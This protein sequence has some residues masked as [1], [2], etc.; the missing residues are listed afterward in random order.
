MQGGWKCRVQAI[1]GQGGYVPQYHGVHALFQR[2]L[3]VFEGRGGGRSCCWGF[4]L[5]EL[6][7]V[8]ERK[9]GSVAVT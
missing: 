1:L 4:H 3:C 5:D 2:L 8:K 6:S 7:K 9:V